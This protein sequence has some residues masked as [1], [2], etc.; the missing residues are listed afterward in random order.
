MK[1]QRNSR[2]KLL[3]FTIPL[4]ILALI[5]GVYYYAIK[6]NNSEQTTQGKESPIILNLPVKI[7]WIRRMIRI[8]ILRN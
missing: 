4:L 7:Q 1:R 8:Q 3:I 6:E 5:I 2:N